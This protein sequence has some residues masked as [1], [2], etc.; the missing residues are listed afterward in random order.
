MYFD[1]RKKV[2]KITSYKRILITFVCIESL[3]FDAVK[4]GIVSE[5]GLAYKWHL[6][7]ADYQL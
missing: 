2:D 4:N 7:K 6:V 5:N 1:V 3:I